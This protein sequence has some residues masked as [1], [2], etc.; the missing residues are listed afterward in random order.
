[1]RADSLHHSCKASKEVTM[2]KRVTI[3]ALV[4]AAFLVLA[5]P[6]MA[7]NGLRQDYTTSEACQ[8]CHSGIAGIPDTYPG[9]P[10]PSMARPESRPIVRRTALSAP[11]ATRRTSIRRSRRPRRAEPPTRGT[12]PRRSPHRRL[13][14]RPSLRTARSVAPPA[15]TARTSPAAWRSTASTPTT[16]RTPRRS[17]SSPTPTSAAPAT[18]ATRTRSTPMR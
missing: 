10:A 17:A 11:A 7:W 8:T 5:V 3:V 15:I 6:A 16:R 9:G 2:F 12:T 13:A 1:M 18:R 14:P 4:V